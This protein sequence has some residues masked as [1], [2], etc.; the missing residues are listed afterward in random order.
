M[1]VN[2]NYK[3]ILAIF[4]IFPF[5]KPNYIIH[6]E[7]LNL[8]Y[9]IMQILNLIII[10]FLLVKNKK[11]SKEFLLIVFMQLILVT[12]TYINNGEI[13][14]A[15]VNSIQIIAFALI[16]Y[17]LT[18]KDIK[19]FFKAMAIILLVLVLINYITIIARPE[20]YLIGYLKKW[21]FGTKNN[22]F[23]IILPAIICNYIYCLYA[24]EKKSLNIYFYLLLLISG[25][26]ILFL[27]SAT[28][29]VAFLITIMYFP[30][31]KFI[32]D[33]NI[34]LYLV[35]YIIVSLCILVFNIQNNFKFIIED[36]LNKDLTFTGR[37]EIWEKSI[38]FI[39]EKPILGYGVENQDYR[40]IKFGKESFI[41]CHNMIL[42]IFYQGGLTLF[43]LFSMFLS[44]VIKN[45]KLI[46]NCNLKNFSMWMI[47][48]Y[49]IALFTEVYSFEVL[50][51]ILLVLSNVY[52]LEKNEK[53]SL[54]E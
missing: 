34:K 16:I 45:I 26:S 15:I 44:L 8:I 13:I 5:I 32:K 42:E 28:S 21:F 43:I 47:I 33:I 41:H 35:I 25:A 46:K 29:L 10:V 9:N 53:E 37:T 50:L 54:N 23:S 6:I 12:S 17:Y 18:Q 7:S 1:K 49:S 51:W 31:R 3:L 36:V 39:K 19:I 14:D 24:K 52:R 20:G 2:I 40:V 27:Q 30:L 11:I 38:D 4:L 48:V 22:H